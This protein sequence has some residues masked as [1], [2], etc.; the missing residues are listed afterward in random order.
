MVQVLF[1]DAQTAPFMLEIM[2]SCRVALAA[3][4]CKMNVYFFNDLCS[5]KWHFL[6]SS[7]PFLV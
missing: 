3:S 2:G 1:K 5:E 4:I 6:A 7:D